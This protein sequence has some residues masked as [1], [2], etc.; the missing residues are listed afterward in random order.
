MNRDG[1]PDLYGTADFERSQVF[2]QAGGLFR[3]V[4]DT[5]GAATEENGMGTTLADI[6]QDGDLDLFVTSISGDETT[7]C[8]LTWGCL[9]NRL[10]INLGVGRFYDA[11]DLFGV[12]EGG[13]GWGPAFA[14]LDNDGDSDLAM[15]NGYR[16]PWEGAT[17]ERFIEAIVPYVEDRNRLW[18]NDGVLPFTEIAAEAGFDDP[19]NGRAL[20]PFDMDRDGDLDLLIT[21]NQGVA[22]LYENTT[23][24]YR[25]ASLRFALAADDDHGLDGRVRVTPT[26]E[27]RTQESW[28]KPYAVYTSS[29]PYEVHV[30][31]GESE[32]PI[33]RIEIALPNGRIYA[34]NDV[35]QASLIT[36]R[37]A[38][39]ERLDP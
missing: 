29:S 7:N 14:D 16:V 21:R 19:E 17:L 38:T 30:G 31:L 27:S 2:L 36:L 8:D 15:T 4:T 10:F 1:I 20:I 37:A 12:R 18:R 32:A 34:W 26:P 35:P 28:L 3:E 24:A 6:D 22:A 25:G 5:C 33:H 39:A 13:W 23:A 9:G 11:T